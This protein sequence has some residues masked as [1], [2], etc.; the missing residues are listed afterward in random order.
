MVYWLG[1][2]RIYASYGAKESFSLKG[3]VKYK[4]AAN[5]SLMVV[6]PPGG[7]GKLSLSQRTDKRSREGET[8]NS[9]H[10]VPAT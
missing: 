7:R 1:E 10:I 3:T 6:G 8:T 4:L 2:W 9:T 5:I